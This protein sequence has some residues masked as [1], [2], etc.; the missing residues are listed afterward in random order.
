VISGNTVTGSIGSNVTHRGVNYAVIHE[1]GT[2]Y[3]R[4][5]KRADVLTR[6]V[7]IPERAPFRTGI[8]ENAE[9]IGQEIQTEIGKALKP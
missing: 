4:H 5:S 1:F 9:Y 7:V 6:R 2:S 8:N 3:M